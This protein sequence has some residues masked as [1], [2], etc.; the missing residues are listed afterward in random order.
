MWRHNNA[1]EL[2]VVKNRNGEATGRVLRGY[3]GVI[4][5]EKTVYNTSARSE[6]GITWFDMILKGQAISLEERGEAYKKSIQSI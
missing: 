1:C 5:L 2:H 6:Y 4:N 3:I